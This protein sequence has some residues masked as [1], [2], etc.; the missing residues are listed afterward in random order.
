MGELDGIDDPIRLRF[1]AAL[2]PGDG[3]NW[4]GNYRGK[5][6]VRESRRLLSGLRLGREPDRTA[7]RRN[8]PDVRLRR[9]RRHARM[10]L[11]PDRRLAAGQRRQRIHSQENGEAAGV[12]LAVRQ[13]RGPLGQHRRH[14]LLR[15][16]ERA[17]PCGPERCR[18]RLR[19]P[20]RQAAP[21]LGRHGQQPV[22]VRKREHRRDQRLL[23]HLRRPRRAGQRARA[24]E[25]LRRAGRR[26]LRERTR[27]A[28]LRHQRRRLRGAGTSPPQQVGAGTAAFAGPGN[29]DESP[30]VRCKRLAFAGKALSERAKQL[31]RAARKAAK[32]GKRKRAK[33]LRRRA[34]RLGKKA[35]RR[36]AAAKRCR[37]SGGASQ[38]ANTKR[39]AHR[40]RAANK[41]R[42]A[43]R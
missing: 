20:Q 17:S 39:R 40:S 42:R 24:A 5:D 11:L 19:V 41:K 16:R 10:R 22:P 12:P 28:V 34:G 8:E 38:G 27:T 18:R 33:R 37:R 7:P 36:S 29:N 30:L 4:K 35:H 15:H 26:R 6:R 25:A 14:R 2:G 13:R 23:H 21:D 31:R 9:R 43:H 1:I 32:A 3:A